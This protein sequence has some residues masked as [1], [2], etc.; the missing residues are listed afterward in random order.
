[1]REKAGGGGRGEGRA[2]HPAS[3]LILHLGEMPGKPYVVARADETE[4]QNYP[5]R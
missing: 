4:N 1:M 3:M 5:K 2:T